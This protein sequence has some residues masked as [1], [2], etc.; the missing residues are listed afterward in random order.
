MEYDEAE[1][2]DDEDEDPDFSPGDAEDDGTEE[3]EE[4]GSTEEDISDT[5][6]PY[7]EAADDAQPVSS[8]RRGQPGAVLLYT[9]Q[10]CRIE[11]LAPVLLIMIN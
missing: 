6:A 3:D 10:Q 1:L 2:V 9:W 8:S 7:A 11:N 4:A 5:N